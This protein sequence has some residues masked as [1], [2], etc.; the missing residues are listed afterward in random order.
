MSQLK[1]IKL[2]T[3]LYSEIVPST[4]KEV[5]IKPFKVGDEKV[6]L[7]A[8]ESEDKNQMVESLKRV[9]M[10]CLVGEEVNNLTSYDVEYLFLKIRSKSVGETA[11]I[12]AKC[13]ECETQ[14]EVVV[15]LD[16]VKVINLENR[17]NKIK[18]TDE[19]F[20]EMKDP[21]VD[22]VNQIENTTE[23]ILKYVSMLVH[24]VYYGEE[25]IDVN[26]TDVQDVLDIIEQLTA[27]Q[28]ANLQEYV[29]N[30]PKLSHEISYTCKHCNTN[31]KLKMEGLSDFF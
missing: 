13:S 28:F 15:D 7:I 30:I 21:D 24:K 29:A 14:N 1:N 19:L 3:P 26:A 5:K 20:F 8:S 17:N 18:V 4:N 16:E 22:K 23:G 6:L 25:V 10:N 27:D 31:N 2:N 11:K 9:M 12:G